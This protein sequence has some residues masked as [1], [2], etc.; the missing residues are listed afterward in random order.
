M[1]L[2][3]R[4][5]K[6]LFTLI[7]STFFQLYLIS[8][9]PPA[10]TNFIF[11]LDIKPVVSGSFAELRSNHFHSGIDIT[12]NGK[13]GLP[14]RCMD[15]G[16]ISR[17]KV[18]PTGYG[19]A[20]YIKHT[21]GYTTVYGHL[22]RYI[23]KID[24]LITA[25]QYKIQSFYID[26]FPKEEIKFKKG[27]IIAYSGNSG[28]SG[29]PHLHFEIR[30]TKTE[31]PINPFGFQSR[32]KDDVKPS[33]ISV[34]LYPL[35]AKASINGENTPQIYELVLYNGAYHLKGNPKVTAAGKIGIAVEMLDYLSGS[36]RKCGIYSLDMFVNNE[37]CYGWDLHK[38]S[39]SESRYINS[40]IDYAYW[41]NHRKRYQRCFKLEN[42]K[43]D[44][45]KNVHDNGL[46]TMDSDK[47]ILMNIKDAAGNK[48]VLK[49]NLYK[50]LTPQVVENKNTEPL[51]MCSVAN[52]LEKDGVTC[53]IPK[54]ALYQDE[55][56]KVFKLA[57][58]TSE[59]LPEFVIGDKSI[60]LQKNI[61]ITLPV[62]KSLENR[63][64]KIALAIVLSNNKLSYIGGKVN[65]NTI[66]AK[67]RSLGNYTFATDTTPPVIKSLQTT[68]GQTFTKN[69]IL[70]FKIYDDF[71]GIHSYN[72]YLN[73]K[74]TLFSYDPKTQT[75]TC[76]LKK[77]PIQEA[78][79]Y[80]L[81][82]VIEDNLLNKCVLESELLIK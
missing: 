36:W 23:P 35:S 58:N 82:L 33:L 41:A 75:L 65:D 6:L 4:I 73:G 5:K 50:T 79:K 28:S 62:P 47:D 32:I 24:S 70:K 34:R 49:L 76:A 48:S 57:Q 59:N 42:N 12:T 25:E 40:H 30:D 68:N 3:V 74:W 15:D 27:D 81:K 46:I 52:T 13:T 17:I 67:T 60:G 20:L 8:Q 54:G 66:T 72:G 7:L 51:V 14:V 77:A 63:N 55:D 37:P 43:L 11:P 21:N 39:F 2:Q 56:F 69:N 45:Y 9:V 44:I 19:N 18:S 78:G 71:S 38:F 61:T 22:N 64:D 1:N 31:E 16:V 26:Y 80:N 10:E 29:G 53:F